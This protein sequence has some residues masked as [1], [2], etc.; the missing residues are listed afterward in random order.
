MKGIVFNVVETIIEK[1]YGPEMWDLLL[2]SAKLDGAYT[3]L[4]NYPDA[5][6]YS[7]VDAAARQLGLTAADT[8]KWIGKRS[9]PYFSKIA[10]YI[11]KNYSHSEDFIKDVNNIIHPEI[12]KLSPGAVCP[13]F[14]IMNSSKKS[15]S[16]VYT[17]PRKLCALAEGF[18][19]SAAELY[20]N[21]ISIR[22]PECV[23]DGAER[24]VFLVEW[25]S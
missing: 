20:Q 14:H 25:V 10:P 1:E 17:S 15:L 4:G 9:M 12:K 22:Q 6:L 19:E 23:H 5:E 13:H 21:N 11:F 18:M 8:L 16:L 7:I 2:T 24:C 3:S